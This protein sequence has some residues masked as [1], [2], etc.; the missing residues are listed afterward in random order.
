[1]FPSEFVEAF[2]Y[3]LWK[4]AIKPECND[5]FSIDAAIAL[6][7]PYVEWVRRYLMINHLMPLKDVKSVALQLQLLYLYGAIEEIRDAFVHG[8][9]Q[10]LGFKLT[11]YS[12]Q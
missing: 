8:S 4:A 3:T 6:Q 9:Q 1:M 7:M 12:Y 10:H 11:M 2:P 5:Y